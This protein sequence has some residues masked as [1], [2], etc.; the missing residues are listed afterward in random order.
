M[1]FERKEQAVLRRDA[2][3]LFPLYYQTNE[4]GIIFSSSISKIFNN[5]SVLKKPNEKMIGQF[6]AGEFLDYESTF[7]E[8][9]QQVPPGHTLTFE[10]GRSPSLERWWSADSI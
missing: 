4:T 2:L 1:S 8:G 6:L 9:I 7:F 3:G 10:K 5:P